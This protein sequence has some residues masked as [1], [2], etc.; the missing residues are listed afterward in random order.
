MA[1]DILTSKSFSKE[2]EAFAGK[3]SL[4]HW[5]ALNTLMKEKEID[6][7]QVPRLLTKDILSKVEKEVKALRLIK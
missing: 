4:S 5:E 3:Y 2:L 6:S 7:D 1:L